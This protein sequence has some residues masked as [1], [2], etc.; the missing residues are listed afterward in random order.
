MLF[1]K[2]QFIKRTL[3]QTISYRNKQRNIKFIAEILTFFLEHFSPPP[4]IDIQHSTAT[5]ESLKSEDNKFESKRM[6]F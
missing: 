1:Y 4:V 6:H 3:P 5:K 2:Q